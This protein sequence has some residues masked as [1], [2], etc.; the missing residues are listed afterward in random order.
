L[1]WH[2]WDDREGVI[3]DRAGNDVMYVT[4]PEASGDASAELLHY[5]ANLPRLQKAA[6]HAMDFLRHRSIYGGCTPDC[7]K[8]ALQRAM[9]P[10]HMTSTQKPSHKAH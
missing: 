8:C 9:Q 2:V 5:I 4:F 1:S 7:P 10:L 3:T 6:N